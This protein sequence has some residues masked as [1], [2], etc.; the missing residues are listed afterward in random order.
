MAK[1]E[2]GM[3][4]KCLDCGAFFYD[5]NKNPIICPKCGHQYDA[6]E[7]VKKQQEAALKASKN[8]SKKLAEVLEGD[9][10]LPDD[11]ILDDTFDEEVAADEDEDIMLE[12]DSELTN[13]EDTPLEDV[14][15]FKKKE[16]VE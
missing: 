9:L 10:D 7:F 6:E 2:W 14:I 1:P 15:P 5:M 8:T 3:K 4:R 13:E 16:N 12:D 11:V